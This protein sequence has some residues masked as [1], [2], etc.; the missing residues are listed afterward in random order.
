MGCGVYG[1]CVGVD[2]PAPS[3]CVVVSDRWC[4]RGMYMPMCFVCTSYRAPQ[5]DTMRRVDHPNIV[6]LNNAF[7]SADAKTL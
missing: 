2:V 3:P 6:E 1:V 5:V 4:V 7:L